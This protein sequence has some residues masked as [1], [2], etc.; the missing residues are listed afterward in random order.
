MDVDAVDNQRN[1]NN[2][3]GPGKDKKCF[4]CDKPGH[5]ARDCRSKGNNNG[6]QRPGWKP[7]P[8]HST[9]SV[10]KGKGKEVD[11]IEID[12]DFAN[13]LAA[14]VNDGD[15]R[16]ICVINYENEPTDDYMS[17]DEYNQYE[18]HE[19]D[20]KDTPPSN[21]ESDHED[22]IRG[23]EVFAPSPPQEPRAK[24]LP[25]GVELL[26]TIPEDICEDWPL[27][28]QP[29][30]SVHTD[31]SD[32][33]KSGSDT[34]TTDQMD[35]DDELREE[36]KRFRDLND[37]KH[38]RK[39][40]L[41][42]KQRTYNRRR[43]YIHRADCD[44]YEEKFK[45]PNRQNE[46]LLAFV[47]AAL[48]GLKTKIRRESKSREFQLDERYS[49]QIRSELYTGP[50]NDD[51]LIGVHPPQ[52]KIQS[53]GISAFEADV[54]VVGH[55]AWT[56]EPGDHPQA[57]PGHPSH[58]KIVWFQCLHDACPWHLSYKMEYDHFPQRVWDTPA[59][60]FPIRATYHRDSMKL[61]EVA[62][63]QSRKDGQMLRLEL[64][65]CYSRECM[66]SPYSRYQECCR[67]NCAVHMEDKARQWHARQAVKEARSMKMPA[68]S[69]SQ[70]EE[71]AAASS[72]SST[73]REKSQRKR[74]GGRR[75]QGNGASSS[76][77][78][79]E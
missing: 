55:Q 13:A 66:E 19:R 54:H 28:P 70:E 59:T 37:E 65:E 25:P 31:L 7:V 33:M 71:K 22:Y 74:R 35:K 39:V 79:R 32:A 17:I 29:V 57:H 78:D 38:A 2:K 44:K 3:N 14:L 12:H 27:L 52:P 76:R 8:T 58:R 9:N 53:V 48:Q 20:L 18:E 36:L 24:S 49:Q 64:K 51:E 61:W 34:D 15:T 5:F 43:H 68:T 42:I 47:Q 10:S 26:P 41:E 63:K 23:R 56:P 40:E 1:H 30:L 4:K 6:N 21:A 73:A 75:R 50:V 45:S 69:G 72:S 67:L 46:E 16:E 60:P 11:N 62:R 77:E